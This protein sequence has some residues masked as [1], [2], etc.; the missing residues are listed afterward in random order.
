VFPLSILASTLL[1]GPPSLNALIDILENSESIAE[2]L[3]LVREYVPEYEAEIMGAEYDGRISQFSHYFSQRYFPLSDQ[4]YWDENTIEDFLRQIPVDLMGFSYDDYH[5]FADFRAGYV[6]MLSLVESPWSDDSDGGRVPILEE[7]AKLVG[8]GLMELIPPEGWKMELLHQ[9]LDETQYA[10]V[11]AFA[12]WICKDT[13]CWVLDASYDE[14]EGETWSH[15]VIDVLTEQWPRVVSIQDKIQGIAEWLE[16]DI[17][18]NFTEL[19]AYILNRKDLIIPREQLPF[20]LDENGQVI[21][22][23]VMADGD[24][25]TSPSL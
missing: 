25:Q 18:R 22:K 10:G 2:F 16:E 7:V 13:G 3:Q 6:L 14:Y 17:K 21:R 20:P 15:D 19:L 12:D 4:T 5:D 11:A 1:T 23:E 8:K 9:I 24:G